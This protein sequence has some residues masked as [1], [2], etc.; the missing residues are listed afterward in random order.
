[1]YWFRQLKNDRSGSDMPKALDEAAE[2]IHAGEKP[3]KVIDETYKRILAEVR[4][5]HAA[6]QGGVPGSLREGLQGSGES[7][8]DEAG[9]RVPALPSGERRTD[10]SR[11]RRVA[12]G[13]ARILRRIRALVLT[14]SPA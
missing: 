9:E 1:M 5:V 12:Y 10:Y 4:K 6:E 11:V 3:K 2:R 14:G 7:P 8:G 13:R